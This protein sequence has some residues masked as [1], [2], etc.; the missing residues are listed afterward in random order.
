MGGLKRSI[1]QSGVF[2]VERELRDR[3]HVEPSGLAKNDQAPLP[4]V[5]DDDGVDPPSGSSGFSDGAL[6]IFIAKEEDL[7][8]LF[9]EGEQIGN[10]LPH[11]LKRPADDSIEVPTFVGLKAF[12]EDLDKEWGVCHVK[13]GTRCFQP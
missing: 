10:P 5:W 13:S 7:R 11:P 8:A 4:S 1:F 2:H 9:G 6:Q 3:F 12:A